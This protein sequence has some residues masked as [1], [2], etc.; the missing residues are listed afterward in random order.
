MKGFD[1]FGK[2]RERKVRKGGIRGMYSWRRSRKSSSEASL[3][4]DGAETY[5]FP[6]D[7]KKYL[8]AQDLVGNFAP[9]KSPGMLPPLT[10]P[11]TTAILTRAQSPNSSQPLAKNPAPFGAYSP[12]ES[13]ISELE[14]SFSNTGRRNTLLSRQV[15]NANSSVA[16]NAAQGALLSREA[17]KLQSSSKTQNV[18]TSN[19]SSLSSGFGD[20]LTI[21]DPNASAAPM[22]I[23]RQS[24]PVRAF[25]WMQGTGQQR[26]D[27]DTV[28]TTTSEDSVPRFRSVNSWVAQQAGRVE[29]P[30]R[31]IPRV[32]S[33]PLRLQPVNQQQA[34]PLFPESATEDP[35]SKYQSGEEVRIS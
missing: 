23:Q 35:I 33:I 9:I 26:G 10:I 8:E 12:H 25:S 6:V 31:D 5:G 19:M 22:Q 29:P 18:R 24:R 4:Q 27:R 28:L 20:G 14:G 15:T 21:P 1:V 16:T 3:Q 2:V 11:E 7:E 30:K 34:A 13:P 32:P 17:S